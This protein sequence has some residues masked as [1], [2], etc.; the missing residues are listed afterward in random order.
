MII[1]TGERLSAQLFTAIL[2][3]KGTPAA[4]INL[5]RV[6]DNI[7]V[8]NGRLDARFFTAARQ[9][10]VKTIQQVL[11]KVPIITGYFG[12]VPGGILNVV[13]RGYSDFTASLISAE[14]RATELQVWKEVDGIFSADPIVVKNAH[15]LSTITPN[16]AAELTYYGSAAIHPLMMEQIMRTGIPLRIKN[17]FKP[18]EAGTLIEPVVK[19]HKEGKSTNPGAIKE[20]AKKEIKPISKKPTALTVKKGICV[21]NIQSNRKMGSFGFM[22]KIF[23]ILKKYKIVVDLITTSEVHVSIAFAC[24]SLPFS[25]EGSW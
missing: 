10:M 7:E 5:E 4:Y 16:E 19:E 8:S 6:L 12:F 11:P 9:A 17:T 15:L 3:D 22:A 21:I 24:L 14:L 2:N 25:G 23:K 1:G 20:F 13:G 18:S